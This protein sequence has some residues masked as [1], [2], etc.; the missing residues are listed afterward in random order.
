MRVVGLEAVRQHLLGRRHK[1][2]VVRRKIAQRVEAK[3][4]KQAGAAPVE[5]ESAAPDAASTSEKGDVDN[6]IIL[7]ECG[8]EEERSDTG[9]LSVEMLTPTEVVGVSCLSLTDGVRKIMLSPRLLPQAEL[10]GKSEEEQAKHIAAGGK[11]PLCNSQ[12]SSPATAL[13]HVK[14]KRHTGKMA[15]A[16]SSNAAGVAKVR[17]CIQI[18][19]S[20]LLGFCWRLR[21][22]EDRTL[23]ISRLVILQMFFLRK[24]AEEQRE[25]LMA[26]RSCRLCEVTLPGS[27]A[28]SSHLRGKRHLANLAKADPSKGAV[29]AVDFLK[30]SLVS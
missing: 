12:I 22:G 18:A 20:R 7:D 16:M 2:Q 5:S 25:E 23:A 15:N 13:Q 24:S 27:D 6:P 26:T 11:C 3:R 21:P 9:V 1:E 17:K 19:K 4:R 8:G 28:A 30:G 29:Q 10:L 14:G